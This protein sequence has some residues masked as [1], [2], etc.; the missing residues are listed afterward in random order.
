MHSDQDEIARGLRLAAV[1]VISAVV[2]ATVVI[3]AGNA[4]LSLRHPA[5]MGAA[6]PAPRLIQTSG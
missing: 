3:G 5:S 4:W 1:A 2:T 6:L